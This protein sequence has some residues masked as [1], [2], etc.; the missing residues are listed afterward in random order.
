M[1]VDAQSPSRHY[2]LPDASNLLSGDVIRIAT[3]FGLIDTD[4]AALLAGLDGKAALQHGHQ[5]G[6]VS[7]LASAL[8]AKQDAT[9]HDALASLSDVQI[10]APTNNQILAFA[11]TKWQPK[12]L[13]VGD[14]SGLSTALGLLAP[15]A[16][17]IFTGS[18]KAPTKASDDNSTAI[19]TTAFVQSV[20]NSITHVASADTAGYATTAGNADHATSADTATFATSANGATYWNGKSFGNYLDQAVLTTSNVAFAS[21]TSAGSL[22]AKNNGA[23]ANNKFYDHY[24]DGNG[25]L[26]FRLVNDAFTAATDWLIVTR[27]GL[28]AQNVTM[29]NVG[30]YLAGGRLHVHDNAGTG[31]LYFGNTDNAYFGYDGNSLFSS[32]NLIANGNLYARTSNLFLG[33][34]DNARWFFDGSNIQTQ[35]NLYVNSTAY[36][37]G[38]INARGG[39]AKDSGGDLYAYNTLDT[40]KGIRTRRGSDGSTGGNTFN[41]FWD[42]YAMLLYVD[43]T[44]IGYLQ[45]SSKNSSTNHE[46]RI[47]ALEAFARGSGYSQPPGNEGP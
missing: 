5:I 24:V 1:P 2:P 10:G 29:Q 7:G 46:S 35:N 31:Y 44:G 15:L 18:P 40:S 41:L 21:V 23:A 16:S 22:I 36:V 17:P 38:V 26:R 19:A 47:A 45:T 39:L 34:Q 14:V 28:T 33:P 13:A 9:F 12:T 27:N 11:G 20:L 6:D 4:V 42:N 32:K 25:V 30:L 3:A 8:A 37:Q 43:Q